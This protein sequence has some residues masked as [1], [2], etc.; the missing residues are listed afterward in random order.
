MS[1]VAS[2]RK[3][4]SINS[5]VEGYPQMVYL[6]RDGNT[7]AIW[8]KDA[9][10]LDVKVEGILNLLVE[11]CKQE[12][13]LF[14]GSY[15]GDWGSKSV[16]I[17]TADGR[18]YDITNVVDFKTLSETVFIWT[19][20]LD[21]NGRNSVDGTKYA[22]EVVG[23]RMSYP[24]RFVS[25]HTTSEPRRLKIRHLKPGYRMHG[26][27]QEIPLSK[28][29]PEPPKT[30]EVLNSASTESTPDVHIYSP[31]YAPPDDVP[32]NTTAVKEN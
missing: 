30:D 26:T 17:Q 18:E 13:K 7:A 20:E 10:F 9:A 31:I 25:I 5:P 2:L 11:E 15:L 6:W 21:D 12:P 3:L 32:A 16:F 29:T 4:E 27:A 19:Q 1:S 28:D 24:I 23:K 8:I 22:F 14:Q